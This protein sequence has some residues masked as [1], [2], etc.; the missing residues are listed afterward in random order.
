MRAE[1]LALTLAAHTDTNP[2]SLTPEGK[3]K[4]TDVLGPVGMELTFFSM[5]PVFGTWG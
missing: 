5:A 4:L 2:F 3:H 1:G